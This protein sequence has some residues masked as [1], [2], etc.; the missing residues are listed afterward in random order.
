VCTFQGYNTNKYQGSRDKFAII[1][2]VI[3]ELGIF[4]LNGYLIHTLHMPWVNKLKVTLAFGTRLPLV[5]QDDQEMTAD[6]A[7]G[8]ALAIVVLLSLL[9]YEA[10]SDPNLSYAVP[11]S[12]EEALLCYTLVSGTIPCLKTFLDNFQ[13]GGLGVY[14]REVHGRDASAAPST[15]LHAIRPASPSVNSKTSLYNGYREP[16]SSHATKSARDYG[17]G[18][19][20]SSVR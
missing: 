1:F 14:R 18:S 6:L 9:S 17:G 2:Y 12:W 11:A 5:F 4:G 16:G 8:V 3:V 20:S 19:I 15:E 7:R 13:T 10:D